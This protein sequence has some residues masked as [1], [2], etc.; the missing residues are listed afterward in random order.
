MQMSKVGRI[1]VKVALMGIDSIHRVANSKPACCHYERFK[2]SIMEL[3]LNI[4]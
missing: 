4:R 1:R 3:Q 2:H